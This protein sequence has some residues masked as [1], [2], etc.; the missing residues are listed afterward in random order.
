MRA[1]LN[2]GGTALYE[3]LVYRASTHRNHRRRRHRSRCDG[4]TGAD[5]VA[6]GIH[7]AD[8]IGDADEYDETVTPLRSTL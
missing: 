7:V 2:K 8:G 6:H 3:P 5:H 1:I 4:A